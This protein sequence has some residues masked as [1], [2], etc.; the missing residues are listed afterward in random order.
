MLRTRRFAAGAIAF[1][2]SDVYFDLDKDGKPTG[3]YIKEQNESN[4][5][6]EEFMLLA[7]KTVATHIGKPN[8]NGTK[9]RT[10]IYRIHDVPNSEKLANFAEFIKRFGYKIKTQGKRVDVSSSINNLL[11]EV[12]G[13]KEQNMIETLAIRSM[14][15]AIYS[16]KNIGHYGLAMKYYTQFTSPIRRYPDM[17]VHRLLTKYLEEDVKN[18]DAE[19]LENTCKHA[20]DME[21][22]AANAERSS[23]KYK[24]IEFMKDKVGQI[25]DGVISSVNTWGI[26]VELNETHC[27]GMIS[28]RDLD[29]DF[30]VFDDK[31]YCI[32]GRKNFR[33]FQLGDD[34]R[35]QVVSAD[36]FTKYLN[37]I[38]VN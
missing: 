38:V 35:V 11:D 29:D 26:Y 22:K 18:V 32:M 12:S 19:L 1:E 13:K 8:A 4:N 34:I 14:A 6:V 10:F 17:M 31:N 21:Q 33:K 20:S 24:Q 15:K 25:F 30:Y 23:I 37:F 3:T 28:I 36:L 16:T 7:N 2:R 5:L 27:E 9:P